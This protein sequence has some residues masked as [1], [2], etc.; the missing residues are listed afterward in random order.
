MEHS[1]EHRVGGVSSRAIRHRISFENVAPD[2]ENVLQNSKTRVFEIIR[3][4]AARF[5]GNVKWFL[6]LNVLLYKMVVLESEESEAVS[7]IVNLHSYSAIGM[8]V[9][10]SYDELNEQFMLAVRKILSSF[11]NF[12]RFGSGWVLKKIDSLDVNV[13]R[14]NPMYTSSYI[15]T[16][17]F[18]N[19]KKCVINIKNLSDKKCFLWSVLAYFHQKPNNSRLTV[20]Y[21]SKFAHRLNTRG[22]N[23]PTTDRDIKKFEILNTDIAIHV[24]AYDNKKFFPYRTS[25]FRTR[26]YQINLLMLKGD[27]GKTHFCLINTANGKNGLSRLLSHLSKAKEQVAVCNFCFHR[28][29]SDKRV[30]RDGKANLMRHLELCSKFQSQR[31]SYPKRGETIKF[32]KLGSTLKKKY[33]IYAD[34][35]TFVVNMDDNESEDVPITRSYT[36]KTA[37]HIPCGYCFVVIDVNG[38][39]A[40]G[41]VLYRSSN[42]NEK[43]M[44]KFLKE[45]IEVGD[46]LSADIKCEIPMEHLSERQQREFQNADKCGLCDEVFTETDTKVRHHAHENGKFLCAAHVSCNLNTRTDDT[47]SCYFHNFSGFDSHF[48]LKALAKCKKKFPV[49]PIHQ[50]DF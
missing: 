40:Y 13:I 41:P 19:N 5:E 7:S 37:R 24:I 48:I 34:L 3:E 10:E 49:S 1:R 31:T 12:V 14:Y 50:K 15:Q 16:P 47:I 27:A 8:N 44:E 35:E 11:D 26:K 18:I 4:H 29:T 22:V 6:V 43:I 39:I 36:K 17:Q 33:T 32:R 45:I 2:I 25:I 28:F 23:F 20:K 42:I 38:D 46:L 30:N 21:L 9:L